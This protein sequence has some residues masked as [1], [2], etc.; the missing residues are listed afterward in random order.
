VGSYDLE[1]NGFNRDRSL[2]G[3]ALET[4]EDQWLREGPR[5]AG[6]CQG[7]AQEDRWDWEI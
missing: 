6:P 3:A 7:G 1:A 2:A 4:P 5:E